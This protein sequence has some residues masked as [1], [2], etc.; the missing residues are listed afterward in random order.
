MIGV[1]RL[2]ELQD[3]VLLK[4]R[5]GLHYNSYWRWTASQQRMK[6]RSTQQLTLTCTA[7]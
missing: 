3:A 5:A 7:L 1:E 2:L 6:M 4:R